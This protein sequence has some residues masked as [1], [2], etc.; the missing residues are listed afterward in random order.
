MIDIVSEPRGEAYRAL[1]HLAKQHCTSFSLVWRDDFTFSESAGNVECSLQT[2]L[3]RE[4]HT[5]EWPGTELLRHKA[6]VCHYRVTDESVSIL[7][8][9]PGLYAWL[10][11]RMPED[12]T[13]YAADGS[14]WLLSI[15]HEKDAAIMSESV[16]I[17]ELRAAIP[18][19]SLSIEDR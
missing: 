1:L 2:F 15:A 14:C 16:P 13:F 8:E 12:L 19:L 11:P 9:V 10:A 5:D 17:E 7:A 3:I 4:E 18:G 6:R